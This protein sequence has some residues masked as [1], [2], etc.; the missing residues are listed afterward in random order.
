MNPFVKK[1]L[2][3]GLI[4]FA[5]GVPVGIAFLLLFSPTDWGVLMISLHLFLS[6]VLGGVAI[7]SSVVYEAESWSVTRCTVTHFVITFGTMVAIGFP[8]GWYALD[9]I[10]TY[11]MFGCMFVGY[12]MVWLIMYLISKK[13]AEELD[14]ELQR[15]K[16]S[17][18]IPTDE[19]DTYLR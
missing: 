2:I 6:G 18:S 19:T 4:G 10:S 12:V 11:I 9:D 5:V 17:Q 15:W 3:V 7:G 14:E 8:M 16:Q 13:Q 1:G